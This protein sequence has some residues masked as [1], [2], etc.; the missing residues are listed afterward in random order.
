MR[1]V[2]ADSRRRE[3][4]DVI[5][6][7]KWVSKHGEALASAT[8]GHVDR[9]IAKDPISRRLIHPFLAWARRNHYCTRLAVPAIPRSQLNVAGAD[10]TDRLRLLTMI[11]E[12]ISLDPRTR[13]AAALVLLYGIRTNRIVQLQIKDFSMVGGIVFISLGSQPL[14]LPAAVGDI[15][16]LA[17]ATRGA[18]RMFGSVEDHKWLIPGTRSGYPLAPA[19]LALRLKSLGILPSHARAGALASLSGQLPPVI[20]ARLTG[21]E[22]SAAIRWSNAVS[23]SNARYAG[24]ITSPHN[25]NPEDAPIT[26]SIETLT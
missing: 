7:L 11:L 18:T 1:T 5:N 17:L 14:A 10:E 20:L 3:L 16:S 12:T 26:G 25:P 23:A 15:A 22:I 4:K 13:L 9:W 24:L 6:F 8:Q 21:L 19:S 2:Q